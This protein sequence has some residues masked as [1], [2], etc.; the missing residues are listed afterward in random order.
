MQAHYQFQGFIDTGDYDV[1]GLFPHPRD[2]AANLSWGQESCQ[3]E[4]S[5]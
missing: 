4:T 5:I 3:A 1:S 2:N